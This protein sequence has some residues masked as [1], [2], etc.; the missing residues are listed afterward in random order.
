MPHTSQPWWRSF[1]RQHWLVF[2]VASLAWLFDSLDQQLF[3]LARDGA[4]KALM[5]TPALAIEYAPYTTSVFLVGWAV[6]GLIFGA[7][8]DRYGRARMLTVCVLLYSLCTGSSAFSASFGQFCFFR[9][10]TG[11]GVGGVFGLAVALIADGVPDHTRAPALGMLQGL[12]LWGNVAAGLVGMG[13]G[14]AAAHGALPWQ[15]QPW[16]VMFLVGAVPAFLSLLVFRRLKEPERWVRARDEGENGES[17][18]G[19]IAGCS[20]IRAGHGTRGSVWCSAAPGSS[21]CGGSAIFTPQS[22]VRLSPGIWLRRA[23]RRPP[24][25]A[26]KPIGPPSP[27]FSRTSAGFSA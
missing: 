26:S 14:L 25:P 16:R 27:S 24:W 7:L 23:S 12:S 2:S 21:D 22:C 3:N 11:L 10:I 13:I 6:G 15:L 20:R 1:D 19:R 9:F 17:S 8:G 5:P 18:S 4:M